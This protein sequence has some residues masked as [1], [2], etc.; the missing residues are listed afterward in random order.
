MKKKDDEIITIMKKIK[1]LE[2]SVR[3]CVDQI[4]KLENVKV[5][6]A[7][8]HQ[9]IMPSP[10][11]IIYNS[12]CVT[13]PT[14]TA[15]I[16]PST[17]SSPIPQLDGQQSIGSSFVDDN[18]DEDDVETDCEFCFRKYSTPK[19]LSEHMATRIFV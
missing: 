3:K 6:H 14:P 13:V 4:D 2:N 17:F 11:Q 12:P 8:Q 5:S 1:E 19:E 16:T 18:I 10:N 9:P 7:V 15:S